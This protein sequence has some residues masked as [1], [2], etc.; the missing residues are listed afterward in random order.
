MTR[1]DDE[2]PIK[3]DDCCYV[4]DAELVRA[5]R[6]PEKVGRR[7]LRELDRK[8]PDRPRFPPKDP[9]TDRRFW[10]AVVH[11]LK[12]RHNVEQGSDEAGSPVTWKENFGGKK[13]ETKG[14]VPSRET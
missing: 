7:M 1:A 4:T 2:H 10:P 8:L 11:Y 3:D 6:L 13:T 9:L 14:R 12:R 5:L